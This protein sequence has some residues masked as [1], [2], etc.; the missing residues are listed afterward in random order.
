MSTINEQLQI[1]EATKAQIKQA[2]IDKHIEV[3]DTDPFS[4]YATKMEDYTGDATAS[5]ADLLFPKTAYVNGEMISGSISDLSNSDITVTASTVNVFK[6][7]EE[8]LNI[9]A[10]MKYSGLI[11]ENSTTFSMVLYNNLIVEAIGLT[12][13]MIMQGNTILGIE[14][15]GKTSEDLQA[16][17]DAQDELIAAQAAQIAELKSLLSDKASNVSTE[18]I[19]TV[20][21]VLG[22]EEV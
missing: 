14:G 9:K 12:S 2:L 17:L 19:N 18:T 5:S 21:E 3:L 10:K 6:S 1:L 13:D 15:T 16:Q 22:N 20:N 11:K 8:Y 4:S 7:N